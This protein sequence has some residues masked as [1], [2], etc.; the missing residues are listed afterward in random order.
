MS[1]TADGGP[2][3]PGPEGFP[4]CPAG[5]YAVGRAVGRTPVGVDLGRSR[6]VAYRGADGAAVVLGGRCSHMGADLAGGVVC[7]SAVRCPLHGWAYGPDGRC[8]DV[9]AGGPVPAF[10]RQAAY[11]TAEVGGHV[12]FFN[13]ASAAAYSL[14]FFDG[15]TPADLRPARP[16]ELDVDAPWYL[17]GAN[18]FDL[19]HFAVA[20]DRTAVGTP[21]VD[22]PSPFARRITGT[23]AVTG[24]SWRD[25]LTRRVA[26]P[27]VTMD[28][29]SWGGTM[30]LVAATFRRT[31]SYGMVNVAPLD[32]RRSRVRVVVWVPRRRVGLLGRADA[33][34]RR[35]F[36]RAFLLPDVTA[37]AG[38][39]WSPGTLIDADRTFAS[40]LA[41]LAGVVGRPPVTTRE[42]P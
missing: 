32:G 14:P 16:F 7:G 34:V 17:V 21:T 29:T 4:E 9:P 19:Q 6:L 33:R 38:T 35:S 1:V 2:P 31:T 24:A 27:T 30:V 8:V 40:Y 5:W 3:L 12:F 20:H 15:V 23:F 22:G 42:T 37:A 39:R 10:A 26:G 25:R 28:V 18:G 36:V 11:P 41:W 13:G